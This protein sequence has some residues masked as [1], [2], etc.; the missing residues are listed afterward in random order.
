[1]NAS[2]CTECHESHPERVYCP[3]CESHHSAKV[4][5][6][7]DEIEPR[8]AY[9]IRSDNGE[10]ST[11]VAIFSRAAVE[12]VYGPTDPTDEES[13]ATLVARLVGWYESSNGPGR[14]FSS[15]PFLRV[16]GRNIVIRQF[17]GLDI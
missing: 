13:T 12:A 2:I 14:W 15:A 3:K 7:A 17:S 1:M 16:M 6:C 8:K 11:R 4:G 9:V 5:P 10:T